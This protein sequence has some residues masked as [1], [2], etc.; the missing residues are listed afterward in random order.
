MEL[1]D[2]TNSFSK[3]LKRIQSG[4]IDEH[5]WLRAAF[6]VSVAFVSKQPIARKRFEIVRR[7]RRL[8]PKTMSGN[9][10]KV[11]VHWGPYSIL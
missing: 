3:P 5:T 4:K 8:S 9:D 2:G 11:D 1:V 10:G 6:G 7:L